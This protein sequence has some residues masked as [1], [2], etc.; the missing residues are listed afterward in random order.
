MPCHHWAMGSNTLTLRRKEGEGGMPARYIP[1]KSALISYLIHLLL[2]LY[3]S[4][5]FCF[6]TVSPLF[7]PMLS[8][9]PLSFTFSTFLSFSVFSSPFFPCH[10]FASL[11]FSHSIY[12]IKT[13]QTF[14]GIFSSLFYHLS[15]SPP[16]LESYSVSFVVLPV[17]VSMG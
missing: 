12:H 7:F 17:T 14:H 9:L 1:L 11:S 10:M 8:S 2:H 3:L 16:C 4:S 6:T 15:R 13:K 5:I